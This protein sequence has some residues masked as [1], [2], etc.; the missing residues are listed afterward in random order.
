MLLYSLPAPVTPFSRIVILKRN[1]NNGKI[2][3]S[4]PFPTLMT[5]FSDVAF[6]NEEN[7]SCIEETF[8]DAINEAINKCYKCAIIALGNPLSRLFISCFTVSVAPSINKLDFLVI[9]RF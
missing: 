8:I 2:P 5:L 6:I 7:T 3:P 4:Y 9:L 1:A